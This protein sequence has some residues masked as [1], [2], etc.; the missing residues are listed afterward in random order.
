MIPILTPQVRWMIGMVNKRAQ[1]A[2]SQ[3]GLKP[4]K[5]LPLMENIP[6][7]PFAQ[8]PDIYFAADG[9]HPS[10]VGYKYIF[11]KVDDLVLKPLLEKSEVATS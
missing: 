5:I 2:L 4:V 9:F 1:K 7:D 6:T 3:R 10:D 8:H 11:S